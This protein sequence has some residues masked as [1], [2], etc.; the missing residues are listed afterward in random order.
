MLAVPG[1]AVETLAEFDQNLFLVFERWSEKQLDDFLPKED[2]VRIEALGTSRWAVYE[3]AND[4]NGHVVTRVLD[5]VQGGDKKDR[6]CRQRQQACRAAGHGWAFAHL[7]KP[8]LEEKLEELSI[9][10]CGGDL[11]EW[12]RKGSARAQKI[13]EKDQAREWDGLDQEIA[14]WAGPANFMARKND[15]GQLLSFDQP[16]AME[17]YNNGRQRAGLSALKPHQEALVQHARNPRVP[18]ALGAPGAPAA[19]VTG[20]TKLGSG[21]YVPNTL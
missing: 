21:L 14:E 3:K 13:I 19:A 5:Y 17:A 20:Y 8:R 1:W 15:L 18:F 4:R 12:L 6:C 10:L 7:E 2:P 16:G 9:K 11:L